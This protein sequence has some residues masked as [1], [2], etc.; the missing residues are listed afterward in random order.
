[1]NDWG[2]WSFDEA[3]EDGF[4]LKIGLE[5]IDSVLA[6]N[7]GLLEA[8]EWSERLMLT[9]IDGHPAGL[10]TGSHGTGTFEAR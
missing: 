10:E 3:P 2:R 6:T 8:A 9:A 1:M 4:R 5:A 7:T